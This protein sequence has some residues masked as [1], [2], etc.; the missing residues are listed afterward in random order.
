MA[1]MIIP[2]RQLASHPASNVAPITFTPEENQK[3]AAQWALADEIQY[4]AMPDPQLNEVGWMQRIHHQL[5]AFLVKHNHVNETR[6]KTVTDEI[7]AIIREREHYDVEYAFELAKLEVGKNRIGQMSNVKQHP[8]APKQAEPGALVNA[9]ENAKASNL[10]AELKRVNE[11]MRTEL[12][13]R[14]MEHLDGVIFWNNKLAEKFGIGSE[15]VN[16][17]EAIIGLPNYSFDA[18]M[19]AWVAILEA[20]PGYIPPKPKPDL[21]A[22][23]SPDEPAPV[24]H[25]PTSAKSAETLTDWFPRCPSCNDALVDGKCTNPACPALFAKKEDTRDWASFWASAKN[26]VGLLGITDDDEVHMFVHDAFEV[27]S[28]KELDVQPS[29]LLIDLAAHIKQLQADSAAEKEYLKTHPDKPAET[30]TTNQPE[31]APIVS[32]PVSG[33]PTAAPQNQTVPCPEKVANPNGV[34]KAITI[35]P[36]QMTSPVPIPDMSRW[37]IMRQQATVMIKS[38]FLPQ[39]IKTPEQALTIMMMGDAL[40]IQPIVALNNINVI[41]QKPT[42]SPQLQL[43]LIRRSGLLEAFKV[44]DDGETCTVVIKR[45][46]EA[47]HTETFSQKDAAAMGLSNKDNWRKQPATMRRWRAISAAC[48]L[49]FSDIV[50]GIAA[51]TSEE[52]DPDYVIEAA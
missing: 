2:S 7:K 25:T 45:K 28:M 44:T 35:A 24:S 4:G 13:R 23:V 11:A 5:M 39:S 34:E 42:V 8:K 36:I 19:A 49:L 40:G 33:I 9:K 10:A 15:I 48:R 16:I 14:G 51:Y 20:D 41:Q 1:N 12:M 43:A 21:A 47:E 6:A 46:G 3:F 52:I 38:G 22:S 37:D 29:V 30:S 27:S 50:W 18:I 26:L 32:T 17:R 31:Q